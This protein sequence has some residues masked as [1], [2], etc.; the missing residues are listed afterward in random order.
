MR[1][2]FYHN[3]IGAFLNDNADSILGQLTRHSITVEQ[4]QRDAWLGQIDL[5]KE[6][7]T[8]CI[9]DGGKVYF[10]YAIPRLSLIHI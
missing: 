2:A 1:R 3:S 10:E 9:A 4:T 6:T 8:D 7:L 5:L